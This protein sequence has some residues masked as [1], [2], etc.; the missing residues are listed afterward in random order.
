MLPIID[1][2]LIIFILTNLLLLGSGRLAT[3]IQMIAVQGVLLGI[4]TV[5]IQHGGFRLR[6]ALLAIGST[7]I[8]GILFPLLLARATRL[9]HIKREL[10]PVIGYTGSLIIGAF[11]LA[12]SLWISSRL[13][14][15]TPGKI[16]DYVLPIAFF[17]I[18]TACFLMISRTKAIT[19]V[20]SYIVLENG[21][22]LFGIPFAGEAPVLIELGLLLDLTVGIFVMGIILY[23]IN[24]EFSSVN[25][26]EL[27]SL[28]DSR[29]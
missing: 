13:P 16:D 7:A 9:V 20:I 25:V 8:K 22:Y 24:R 19:Q 2:L 26:N 5:F 27:S 1:S 11:L 4:L 28:K 3:Y 14:I 15:P 6:F 21:I 29:L 10:E 18:F 12:L 17:T 23:H